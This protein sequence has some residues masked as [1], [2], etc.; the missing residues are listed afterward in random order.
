MRGQQK[1][2]YKTLSLDLE[3]LIENLF[4]SVQG[5]ISQ[6]SSILGSIISLQASKDLIQCRG[7][8]Q[9]KEQPENSEKKKPSRTMGQPW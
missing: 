8:G 7:W 6:V 3:L 1:P 2:V 4:A 9:S 5:I